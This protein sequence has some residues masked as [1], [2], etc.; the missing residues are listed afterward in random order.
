MIKLPKS[1]V[2]IFTETSID[3]NVMALNVGQTVKVKSVH[4]YRNNYWFLQQETSID[5]SFFSLKRNKYWFFLFFRSFYG[6]MKRINIFF[7]YDHCM[8]TTK[9]HCLE[10]EYN[11]SFMKPQLEQNH[12]AMHTVADLNITMP[13]ATLAAVKL[14]QSLGIYRQALT[15]LTTIQ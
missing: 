11:L 1:K 15:R 8:L 6:A 3:F 12:S 10:L 9:S 4:L 14:G 7:Q 13:A 2:F 5:F